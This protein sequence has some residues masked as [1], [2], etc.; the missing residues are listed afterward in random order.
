[1]IASQYTAF[2]GRR[3]I[4]QGELAEVVSKAK[5]VVDRGERGAVLIF[6]DASSQL[7]DIDLHGT[8]KDIATQLARLA[9]PVA[10]LEL[11]PVDAQRRPGRPKL[12][13]MAR[14]VTLLPRHWDWLSIQPG[15][16]SVAL[17][18]LVE[19]ARRQ[20]AGR[21]RT[22]QAQESA[23]RFMSAM[24]GDEPGFEEALRALFAKKEAAFE[25]QIAGWP[26]DIRDHAKKLALI[27][28][29]SADDAVET[30]GE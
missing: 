29:K 2:E 25:K 22:R 17:R 10:P 5:A 24:A 26:I 3:R 6:D 19:D 9:T 16:A 4:A 28:F 8:K 18:K 30:P 15:G 21:D 1:M 14:E 11:D 27:V 12:G 7:F 23:Y 13:V 20:F